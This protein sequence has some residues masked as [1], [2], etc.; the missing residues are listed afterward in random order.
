MGIQA[1]NRITA[2]VISRLTIFLFLP[3]LQIVVVP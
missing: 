1:K 2:I 3:H